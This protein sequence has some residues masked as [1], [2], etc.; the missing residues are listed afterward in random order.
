MYSLCSHN[1]SRTKDTGQNP[2][3]K[4]PGQYPHW[5]KSP[6]DKRSGQNLTHKNPGQKCVVYLIIKII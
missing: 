5:S 4:T 1:D 6:V 2:P 3:V